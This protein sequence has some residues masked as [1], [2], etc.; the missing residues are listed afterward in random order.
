MRGMMLVGAR[1][2]PEPIAA[3]LKHLTEDKVR[4]GE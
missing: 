2:D 3:R 1:L 4:R